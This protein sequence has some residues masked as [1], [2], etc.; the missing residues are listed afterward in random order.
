MFEKLLNRI[1]KLETGRGRE[2]ICFD[3]RKAYQAWK[4]KTG[5]AVDR[6]IAII[7]PPPPEAVDWQSAENDPPD[8]VFIA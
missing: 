2:C 7:L 6:F 1:E 3:T 5:A 8:P 4:E